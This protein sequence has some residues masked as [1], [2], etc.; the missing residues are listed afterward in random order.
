MYLAGLVIVIFSLLIWVFLFYQKNLM[1]HIAHAGGGI[2]GHAYT[3]TTEA[4]I[5]NYHQGFRV[6]E[7]DI[8]FYDTQFV[9]LHTTEDVEKITPERLKDNK[10]KTVI[11]ALG[12][13]GYTLLFLEDVI[14]FAKEYS[15]I[16][17]IFD[18]KNTYTNRT[19]IF[20]EIHRLMMLYKVNQEQIV[21]QVFN[22]EEA[23]YAQKYFHRLLYVIGRVKKN[24]LFE[25]IKYLKRN[26]IKLASIDY[27]EKRFIVLLSLYRAL[28]FRE[29]NII[30][31][32]IND[33]KERLFFYTLGINRFFTD[34][35]SP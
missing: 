22:S 1:T 20:D 8:N 25:F 15:D 14:K 34:Q 11:N 9:A 4:F 17:I 10:I 18:V 31:Y 26:D 2:D 12:A 28:F 16:T 23:L 19:T 13:S 6:F 27:S 32:T 24:E 30:P 5:E 33:K 3:N 29:L 7:F 21:V 35:L